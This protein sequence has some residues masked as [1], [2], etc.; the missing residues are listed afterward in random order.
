M[1]RLRNEEIQ[2]FLD[3]DD[4]IFPEIFGKYQNKIYYLAVNI[5]HNEADSEEAIQNTF[6]EVIAN[7]SALRDVR[8]FNVWL[9]RIAYHNTLDIYRK[10][11]RGAFTKDGES[12][13]ENYSDKKGDSGDAVRKKT[14]LE[15]VQK[16]ID[17]LPEDMR[18]VCL[19]RFVGECSIEEIADI[20]GVP[21]GTVKSRLHRAKKQLKT[22]LSNRQVTPAVYLSFTFTPLMFRL[23]NSLIAQEAMDSDSRAKV[24]RVIENATGVTA[25]VAAV[26]TGLFTGFGASI[27]SVSLILGAFG[28]YTFLNPAVDAVS[29]PIA[30][31]KDIGYLKELTNEDLQ[32]VL[33]FD[34]EP[35]VNDIKVVLNDT[36][37]EMKLSN[38]NDYNYTFIVNKNGTYSVQYRDVSQELVIDNI[39]KESP[40]LTHLTKEDGLLK[41]VASDNLAGIDFEKSYIQEGDNTFGLIQIG[42]SSAYLEDAI[43]TEAKLYLYDKTGNYQVYK[44]NSKEVSLMDSNTVD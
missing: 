9:Y 5:L 40:V 10:N 42:T 15:A 17:E 8:A 23:Y 37:E 12:I 25:G 3:G 20:M 7:R 4:S 24:A 30:Q 33:T 38:E 41:V 26:G 29:Q 19:L 13:I 11:K 22:G 1:S 2:K 14:I 43:E 36:N 6:I 31:L 18:E 35:D 28:T 21:V 34:E 44:I 32:I 16:E 27:I 39:D